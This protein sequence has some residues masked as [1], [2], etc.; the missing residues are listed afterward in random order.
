MSEVVFRR[1]KNE[2]RILGVDDGAFKKFKDQT[3][4]LVGVVFRGGRYLEGVLS[5]AITVDGD[6]STDKIIEMVSKTRHKGHLRVIMLSGITFGGL[7]IVDI[8]RIFKATKLPVIVVTRKLPDLKAMDTA[9]SRVTNSAEKK[10]RL[11]KGGILHSINDMKGTI[12]IQKTG[13]TL[14]DAEEILR[15]STVRGLIPEPLRVAHL[16]ASGIT[17]GDSKG[18]A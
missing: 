12:V 2:V 3:T 18:R 11:L 4:A 9:I 5:E 17:T 1:V 15:L 6:D 7:N 16:I 14:D 10:E 13:L 8:E